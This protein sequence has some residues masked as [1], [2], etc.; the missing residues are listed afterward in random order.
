MW[1]DILRIQ[2]E[3]RLQA[4]YPSVKFLVVC[5]YSLCS[6]IIISFRVDGYPVYLIVWF[7]IVPALSAASG[8]FRRFLKAFGKVFSLALIIFLVQSF[9]IP[10][11]QILWR[12]GFLKLYKDGLV[13]GTILGFSILNVAGIFVWFFQT[14]ENK[15]LSGWFDDVGLNHKATYVF[16]STLQMIQVMGQ[17]SR[18]I[19]DAQR[20]R[21]VETE[22]NL[23]VRAKA[24]VPSIVPLILTSITGAEERVLTLE[25]KGFDTNCEKTRLFRLQRSKWDK[26]VAGIAIAVTAAVVGWRILAWVL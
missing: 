19:M 3:N 20:A 9:V 26:P 25:S 22:G 10:G 21:G 18:M 13:S 6:M 12:L 15:E 14:T 16:L 2:K 5:L 24:F 11:D 23:L 4:V 7:F 8:I 1:E 17:S